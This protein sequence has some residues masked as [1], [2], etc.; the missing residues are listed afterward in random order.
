MKHVAL[1]QISGVSKRAETVGSRQGFN[2]EWDSCYLL[3]LSKMGIVLVANLPCGFDVTMWE[4]FPCLTVNLR[5][6]SVDL[7]G[8][9]CHGHGAQYEL[10]GNAADG[11]LYL[12]HP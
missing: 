7:S 4:S 10:Y 2:K 1:C 11:Y 12:L 5:P 6:F 8:C 3:P 9:S